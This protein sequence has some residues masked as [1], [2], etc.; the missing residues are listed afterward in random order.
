MNLTFSGSSKI[1]NVL[2]ILL[3]AILTIFTTNSSYAIDNT[4]EKSFNPGLM[5]MGHVSNSYEWHIL[6]TP[7]GKHVSIPLPV[8]LYSSQTGLNIFMSS[9]LEH[10]HA[11]YNNF[12]I[13]KEGTYKGK[14][15]EYSADDGET[16][17]GKPYD[18]SITKNL[19]GLLVGL[20]L[21][22]FLVLKSVKIAYQTKG[23]PPR[24]L[25]SVIEPIVIFV[26]DDI[27]K[28]SIGEKYQKFLPFLL[29]VF[30]MIFITNLSGIV[31]IVPFGANVTGNISVTL[32]LALFTFLTIHFNAN[33]DYW[34]HIYNTPGV[35]W[36]MKFPVPIMPFV[37]FMS[38]LLKPLVLAIRLFANILAGHVIILAF[39]SLIFIFAQLSAV[40]AGFVSPVTIIFV[41]F[42][43]CIE[44]LV[45]F[46]Q[47]FVFTLLS[48]IFIG[49]AVAEKH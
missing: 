19:I 6:T 37:E 29:S 25:L 7:S 32:G 44:M 40:A 43:F 24:G 39:V 45:A 48:A 10:G 12:E 35:P 14:I 13:C 4:E 26:R 2:S 27:V 5:I 3:L 41:M 49:M 33:K 8:I 30:F 1:K 31:P 22:A 42:M 38:V 20:T 28:S 15:V 34:K 47:A 23:K 21:T 16:L 46:I 17:I 18:F 9:K 11:R 36:W